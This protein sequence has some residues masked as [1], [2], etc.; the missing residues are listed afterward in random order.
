VVVNGGTS[1]T[2]W[3]AAGI[4]H[5]TNGAWTEHAASHSA[6]GPRS[7]GRPSLPTT[8]VNV[9]DEQFQMRDPKGVALQNT[10]YAIHSDDDGHSGE[11]APQ[12]NSIRQPS[13]VARKLD[14]S[15]NWFKFNK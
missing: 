14:F 12:G 15:T 9:F 13:R 7:E 3:N 11:T 10:P 5:G 8:K 4:T 2:K 6:M 1:F